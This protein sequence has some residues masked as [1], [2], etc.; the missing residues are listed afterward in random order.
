MLERGLAYRKRSSVNWCPSCKTVLANEQVEDGKCFRCG[1]V[2]EQKE[3]S[4]W[5]FKITAYSQRLLDD[6]D[7]LGE[8]PDRVRTI[9]VHTQ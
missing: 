2:V 7:Q 5:F 6:L 3:L 1:S 8:W 4:Q 9:F